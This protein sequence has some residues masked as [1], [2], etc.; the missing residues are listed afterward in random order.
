MFAISSHK[1]LFEFGSLFKPLDDPKNIKFF[2]ELFSV[3][4]MIDYFKLDEK[5]WL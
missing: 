4:D 2:N 1:N 3:L 5:I